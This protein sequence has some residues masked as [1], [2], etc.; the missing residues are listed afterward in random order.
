MK[1]KPC[2]PNKHI[3]ATD[4]WKPQFICAVCGVT[5]PATLADIQKFHT[6]RET[7]VS[8]WRNAHPIIAGLI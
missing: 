2:A 7:E 6:D 3:W 1:K 8:K 5:R 4:P